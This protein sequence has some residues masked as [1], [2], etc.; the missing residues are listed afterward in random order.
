M[1]KLKIA[2]LGLILLIVLSACSQNI[3]ASISDDLSNSEVAIIQNEPKKH[4]KYEQESFIDDSVFNIIREIYSKVDFYAEFE[5]GDT[6][7]YD[8]YR[9]QYLKLL[10]NEATF[11]DKTSG[12]EFYINEFNEMDYTYGGNLIKDH[13]FAETYDP[14][15]YIYYFFDMDGDKSPELCIT[16]EIRF[17][18]IFKY[19]LHLDK[20]ILWY[21][22]PTTWIRLLGSNKLWFYGGGS[23]IEYAYWN[24]NENGEEVCSLHFYLEGFYNESTKQDD[25]LYMVAL[26]EYK[27]K[28]FRLPDNMKEQAILDECQDIN[29]FRVT[30][31]QWNKLTNG[32]FKARQLAEKN[33]E[34]VTYSYDKLFG[35]SLQ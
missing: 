11:L 12:K 9:K 29:Y 21:E 18:Y 25:I 16:N 6:T 35:D 28:E 15:N 8:F 19:D 7:V 32:F 22:V 33:I 1:E 31:E 17:I 23:P 24:L 14:D 34:E 27:D 2:F 3:V 5:K 4:S 30:E 20:F 26:P 13:N 10:K